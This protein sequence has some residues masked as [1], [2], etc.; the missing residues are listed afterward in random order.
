MPGET[1]KIKITF[2]CS[3]CGDT[4]LELPDN[5]TD[6]SIAICKSCRTPFGTYGEIKTRAINEAKE[7]IGKMARETFKKA[8]AGSKNVTFR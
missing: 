6:E 3:K 8:F 4:V 1:D 7:K 5:Y 2:T